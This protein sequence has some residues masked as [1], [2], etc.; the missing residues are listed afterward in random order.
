[1]IKVKKKWVEHSSYVIN[2]SEEFEETVFKQTQKHQI[3]KCERFSMTES[4][5]KAVAAQ[6]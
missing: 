6:S 2:D 1:M 5:Q 4:I 3:R